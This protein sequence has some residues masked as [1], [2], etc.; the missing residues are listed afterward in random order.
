MGRRT[1][2]LAL[3]AALC[4]LACQE[5]AA[6]TETA[7]IKNKAG[8]I[9]ATY[10]LDL[11][12]ASRRG[13]D[14]TFGCKADACG[15][16]TAVCDITEIMAE[17]GST[18]PTYVKDTLA[19]L[20]DKLIAAFEVR[21]PG[22][23]PEIVEPA[24]ER[25]FGILWGVFASVRATVDGARARYSHFYVDVYDAVMVVTCSA[26]EDRYETSKLAHETLKAGIR[27]PRPARPDPE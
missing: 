5:A 20:D 3:F 10:E 1:A 21:W 27:T 13:G 2:N 19:T 15:G 22:S 17:G 14:L 26:P 11:W 6:E 23:R 8:S 9:A 7:T 12:S 4:C 18:P 24:T 16:T 25:G